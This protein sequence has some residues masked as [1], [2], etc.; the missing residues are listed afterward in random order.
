MRP[1]RIQ[2]SRKRGFNLQAASLAL[3]GLPATKVTRPGMWGNHAAV[4]DGTPVGEAA[5]ASFRRWVDEE[6]SWAWKARAAIDLR[7]RNLACWCKLPEPGKPDICHAA[8]LIALADTQ[9]GGA[10]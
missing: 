2:L 6:A 8:V 4:R 10:G 3:N 7:G 5:V 1:Q 9:Q